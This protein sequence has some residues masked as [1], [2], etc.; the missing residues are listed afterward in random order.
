LVA[1]RR[2]QVT[3]YSLWRSAAPEDRIRRGLIAQE[4]EQI[5]PDSILIGQGMV[6][7]IQARSMSVEFDATHRLLTIHLEDPH[8]LKENDSVKLIDEDGKQWTTAVVKVP[9]ETSFSVKGETQV[10]QVFVFGKQ[11]DDFLSV[12]YNH[13]FITGISAVQELDRQVQA[14]QESE[15]RIIEL[16]KK[17]AR[18]SQLEQQLADL[19]SQVALLLGGSETT[20]ALFNSATSTRPSVRH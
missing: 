19:Q 11:V 17:V 6:A 14:L 15:T 3:D 5:L 18:M 8:G 13:V 20:P 1:I 2:L 10:D 16:E 4:L 7:N 9:S 12:D